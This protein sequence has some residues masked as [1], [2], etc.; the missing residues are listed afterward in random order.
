MAMSLLCK[1][2]NTQE[3]QNVIYSAHLENSWH[4][5]S[6]TY[7]SNGYALKE[8]TLHNRTI[9]CRYSGFCNYKVTSDIMTPHLF[10]KKL[11]VLLQKLFA[12]GNIR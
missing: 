1:Y 4:L 5:P 11:I 8:A 10:W 3:M 9:S 12:E 7:I 2:A 6:D